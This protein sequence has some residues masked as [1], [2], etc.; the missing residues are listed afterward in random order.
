[1]STWA[2]WIG[3]GALAAVG[4]AGAWWYVTEG[5]TVHTVVRGDTLSKLAQRYEVTVD[6]LR[7]WNTI[8]GDLIEVGDWLWMWPQ[9]A[10]EPP[11][12]PTAAP[13]GRRATPSRRVSSPVPVAPAEDA[14]PAQALAMPPPKRCLQGPGDAD[15][16]AGEMVGSAGL[17]QEDA[18]N[19]LRAFAPQLSRCTGLSEALPEDALELDILV[20]CTGLVDTVTIRDRGD[21]PDGV[22]DC[23]VETLRFAPFPPHDLPDGDLVI[24]PLRYR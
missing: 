1:M 18:S 16:E 20:A 2:R 10:P 6:D 22:A 14:D 9:E 11:S 15:V 3:L 12:P 13:S 8:D 24:Y 4:A 17:S 19:A 7:R 5:P 21:W 23:M